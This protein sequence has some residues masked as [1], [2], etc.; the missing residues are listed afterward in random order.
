MS[1][2]CVRGRSSRHQGKPRPASAKSTSDKSKSSQV[3]N[4]C[5]GNLMFWFIQVVFGPF[6]TKDNWPTSCSAS[7]NSTAI[8]C[9]TSDHDSFIVSGYVVIH[10]QTV[11]LSGDIF[12]R[13]NVL[14]EHFEQIL[15]D[16]LSIQKQQCCSIECLNDEKKTP[17]VWTF[18]VDFQWVQ[19]CE[20]PYYLWL[21]HNDMRLLGCV[22][23]SLWCYHPDQYVIHKFTKHFWQ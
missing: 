19:C 4:L 2:R 11:N 18:I 16:T 8:T 20:N 15:T 5:S 22:L 13:Q 3:L 23:S 7:C 21:W 6:A 1:C 12:E 14:F 9:C 17:A 10:W